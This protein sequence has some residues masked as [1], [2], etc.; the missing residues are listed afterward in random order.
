M[1]TTSATFAPYADARWADLQVQFRLVDNTAATDATPS[2]TEADISQLAQTHDGIESMS[3]RYATLETGGWPLDGTMEIM[4]ND[5]SGL[6]MGFWS[7]ISGSD[8]IFTIPPTLTFT[9]VENHSSIG[10]TVI[11]DDKA[12]WYPKEF[13]ISAYD[14]SD[15]LLGTQTVE[16]TSARQIVE[17]PVEN[18]RKVVLQFTK[19][20]VAHQRVR[21]SEIIFG[22]V[23]YFDKSNIAGGSLLYEL[24]PTADNLPSNELTITIDNSDRKYNMINP[25]GV[26]AYLQQ[27]QP[28]DIELGV[29]VSKYGIEYVNMGCFYFTESRAEDNA[30]T[31]EITAHDRFYSLDRSICRIG[32][33]GTWT[34]SEAVAAVIADSGLPITTA[35]PSDIGLRT[36]NKCIPADTMHREALRLIAQAAMCTCYFNRDDE[37]VFAEIATGTPVDTLHNDNMSTVAKITVSE[38]INTVELTVQDKYADTETVY[39]AA[40]VGASETIQVWAVDNSLAYD[41]N[42]VAAW[43]LAMAQHRLVYEM[44]E[45]GN[46]AREIMDTVT[47]YDAYGENRD[48]VITKEQYDFGDGLTAYTKGWS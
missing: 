11:F 46:P 27:S 31:A 41:G 12:D 1:Q 16:C 33:T 28:L 43:L 39:T 36:V 6:Q 34:V 8:G 32:T 18:Y 17:M 23:Q 20:R 40:N 29:G 26:Y 19:T 4:P 24:S 14:V 22:I 42:S 47:V 9:F 7:V 30:M 3:A 37:L 10:F 44:H 2:A 15:V 5:T 45:R 35:I 25:N 13:I 48:A 21:V 38:R